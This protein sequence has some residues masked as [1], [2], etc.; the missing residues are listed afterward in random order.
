MF[1]ANEPP[2]QS[3]RICKCQNGFCEEDK[4]GELFC[5]CYP[6]F[7]GK[8]CDTYVQRARAP[9]FGNMAALLIPLTLLL[10][11][12]AAAGIYVVIRKRPL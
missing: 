3:P 2:L 1:S 11:A 6:E 4:N 8:Y 10:V 7:R 5:N 9:T 12:L